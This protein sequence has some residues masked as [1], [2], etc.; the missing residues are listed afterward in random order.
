MNCPH[1]A[2]PELPRLQDGG[3]WK[4]LKLV[5][6]WVVA[7]GFAIGAALLT[8]LFMTGCAGT[9]GIVPAA[10]LMQP[11]SVTA[12]TLAARQAGQADQWPSD[13]WWEAFGDAQLNT[14]IDTALTENGSPTLR[15]AQA[16]L[17]KANAIAGVAESAQGITKSLSASS[18]REKFSENYIYPPPLGGSTYT[19]NELLL[20]FSLDLDFWG[21]NSAAIAAAHAQVQATAADGQAARLALTTSVTRAWFQLQRL[22]AQREVSLASLLQREQVL[23]LTRQRADAGLDTVAEL[24]QAEAGQPTTQVEVG[25]IDE[26]I[27]LTRNQLA[28]LL[29][30]GPDRGREIPQPAPY[31]PRVA[32]TGLPDNL[33]LNLL[34]RRADLAAARWRVVAATHDIDYAKAQFYPDINLTASIGFLSLGGNHF[35]QSSSLN[36]SIGPALSLPLFSGTLRANLRGTTA[37]YDAAVEQ[38][39]QTLIDAVKDVAD[40]ITSLQAAQKQRANQQEALAKTSQAYEVAVARYQAGAQRPNRSAGPTPRRHR[41]GRA[42]AGSQGQSDPGTRRWFRAEAAGAGAVA[43][44]GNGTT[45]FNHSKLLPKVLQES[46]N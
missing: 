25:Q 8:A 5:A 13:H 10:H 41:S 6:A 40:Q 37:D 46:R 43:L 7:N 26:A 12:S 16:R 29:G 42:R 2:S 39:N 3:R 11:E 24:R 30:Q 34:G 31:V 18:T 27:A 44:T 33:T 20:N 4:D 45:P 17:A 9:S 21:K 38:Y 35:L 15:L 32:D 1:Q 22:Y 28:A 14:L 19:I 36:P 23:T